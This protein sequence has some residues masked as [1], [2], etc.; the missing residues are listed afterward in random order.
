MSGFVHRANEPAVVFK[1][2]QCRTERILL[3]FAAVSAHGEMVE[4]R[5]VVVVVLGRGGGPS[6]AVWW[7][8][9]SP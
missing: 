2:T 5:N 9:H 4:C 7:L 8:S 1:T 6:G 3:D